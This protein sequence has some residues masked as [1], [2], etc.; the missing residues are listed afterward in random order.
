MYNYHFKVREDAIIGNFIERAEND[1]FRMVLSELPWVKNPN[2]ASL[3]RESYAQ[4]PAN[5]APNGF[6]VGLYGSA[7]PINNGTADWTAVYVERDA[8]T[9]HIFEL[10]GD[11]V[12][13]LP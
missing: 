11:K 1:D 3:V 8:T 13:K 10:L 9:Q 12:T 2:W 5:F 7:P 4:L 6:T